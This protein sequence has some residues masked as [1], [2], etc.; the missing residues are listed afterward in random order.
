MK[1]S[2]QA[3][4]K[5][6]VESLEDR[7]APAAL[8][9]QAALPTLNSREVSYGPAAVKSMDTQT[10][11]LVRSLDWV[12]GLRPNHNETMIRT[13]GRRRHRGRRR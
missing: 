7:C 12:S 9:F 10:L 2:K 1:N 6:Q 11:T 5:L 3:S 4:R 8:T 13:H